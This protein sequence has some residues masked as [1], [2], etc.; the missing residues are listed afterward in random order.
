MIDPLECR[1]D[2][3][4]ENLSTLLKDLSDNNLKRLRAKTV[5][6]ILTDVRDMFLHD[7]SPFR[8]E[9]KKRGSP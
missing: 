2:D 4:R 6:K 3:N 7:S 1:D 5:R 9:E 8:R